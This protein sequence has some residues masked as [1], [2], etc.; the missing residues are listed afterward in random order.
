MGLETSWTRITELRIDNADAPSIDSQSEFRLI[1][2]NQNMRRKPHWET[3]NEYGV[4][5]TVLEQ[6]TYNKAEINE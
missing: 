5:S 2:L 4:I 3:K 6:A 1:A